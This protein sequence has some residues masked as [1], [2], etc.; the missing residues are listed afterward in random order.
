[1]LFES[2]YTSAEKTPH[3]RDLDEKKKRE[4]K[5][6]LLVLILQYLRDEGYYESVQQ[7]EK[8]SRIPSHQYSVCDNID[9][10]SIL[11]DFESY[12]YVRLHKY[13]SICK[14]LEIQAEPK[15]KIKV[16]NDVKSSN[17]NLKK[18]IK[19]EN[20]ITDELAITVKAITPSNSI[21]YNK[22]NEN[23]NIISDEEK[24]WK[25]LGSFEGFSKEWKDF[26]EIIAKEVIEKD[27]NVK[28][29]DII[30]LENAK[31]LLKESI[32][33][34][35]KYPEFF[36]GLL[37]PWKGLLLF[38]P[39]GTGK[40]LLAKAVA[41]ECKTT[42]FNISASSVVSKWRGDS[43]KLIR[44]MF[45]LARHQAPSTIFIDE[46]DS[47]ASKRDCPN[48]HEASRRLKSELLVQLDGILQGNDNVFFLT[49]SN[50]PWD[51]DYAILRRLE[52]RILV[53]LPDE[54]ARKEMLSIFLPKTISAK[55]L[56]TA[57]VSYDLLAQ[58]FQG[59]SGADIKLTCK[60]A[61]MCALRPVF[62]KLEERKLTKK[63]QFDN[64]AVEPIQDNQ[65][66]EA[67][68]RTKPTAA[69][70]VQR[71]KTWASEFASM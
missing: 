34:P 16:T 49:T 51:L 3:H 2:V 68:K 60:E 10:E 1:M 22:L 45:E 37:T 56:I 9:L 4:R 70:H 6:N 20:I 29:N 58:S 52:K 12:Y 31:N 71:Y 69:N 61:I 66:Y 26:A 19:E 25:S 7:L 59:Y 43:E 46:L 53:G 47:L 32:V 57:D 13:P 64:I 38:G 18:T 5:R 24:L 8:E 11:Q 15:K 48:E 54:N 21:Q 62:S 42:F 28:W 55:P 33:Y 14:K 44:V 30:G 65:V 63:G 39:P 17:C 40:T 41:T 36:K 67:V 27:L 50:L 35:L 23:L